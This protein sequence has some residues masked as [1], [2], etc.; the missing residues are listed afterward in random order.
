MPVPQ[1]AP[2]AQGAYNAQPPHAQQSYGELP[3]LSYNGLVVPNPRAPPLAFGVPKVQGYNP[4]PDAEAIYKAT[5]RLN[6]DE[7]ALIKTLTNIGVLKM[8]ALAEFYVTKHGE[9]LVNLLTKKTSGYFSMG[10]HA[11]VAG[12]LAW[13]VE[14]LNQ[15]LAGIGTDED[16]LTEILLDRSSDDVYRLV[17]EYKQRYGTDLAVKIKGDLSG[18]A[19]KMFLMALNARRPPDNI[20]VDFAAVEKDILAL[21][22]GGQCKEGYGDENVFF[23]VIITRSRPH[24]AAVIHGYGQKYRSL[25]KVIKWKFA[26]HAQDGL[27]YIVQGVKPK[28][29]GQGIWR[30]AKFLDKAMKGFG[31]KDKQL[32]YR[33]VRAHW[34]PERMAA[35]SQAYLQRTRKTLDARVKSE[36]SGDYQRLMIALLK[37]EQH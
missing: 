6:T 8:D 11:L 18:V 2:A 25:T 5:N 13:D 12:P 36:T 23:D 21:Y 30:D 3:V 4:A 1:P 20:P 19:E 14:L 9:K 29:D 7:A 28:R 31:T 16:L 17:V 32:V 35:I 37:A 10:I 33:I 34:K 15:A 22:A 24:L 26:G 27:L